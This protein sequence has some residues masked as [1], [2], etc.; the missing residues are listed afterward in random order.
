MLQWVGGILVALVGASLKADPSKW[1]VWSALAG[2]TLLWLQST[3]WLTLPL[4]TLGFGSAQLLR[5]LLGPP[6]AWGVIHYLLDQ[7]QGYV[8]AGKGNE[9]LHFHRVTLFKYRRWRVC[10]SRWPWSGWL[11]PVERSGHTTKRR[12]SVFRAPDDADCA[13]GIAGQTWAR[14]QVVVVSDLPSLEGTP[15]PQDIHEY[16]KRSWVSADWAERRPPLARSFCGIP[17]QT[18]GKLWGVIVIDSRG[19]KIAGTRSVGRYTLVSR[20]LGKLLEKV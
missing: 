14:N 13:E 1:S 18:K 17:V 10:F 9:P 11:T 20:F 3:A 6:W 5:R 8:F 15:S 12:I 19:E 4:L 7:F 16:A 2:R